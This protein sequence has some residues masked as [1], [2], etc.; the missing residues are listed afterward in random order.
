MD[1]LIGPVRQNLDQFKNPK[2]LAQHALW[3][4]RSEGGRP[5]KRRYV[6]HF[7]AKLFL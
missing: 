1:P 4:E 7:N 5:C 2:A 3:M 6:G